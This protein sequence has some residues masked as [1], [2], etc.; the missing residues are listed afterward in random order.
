MIDRAE[1]I[2]PKRCESCG[3]ENIVTRVIYGSGIT[4]W[5]CMDCGTSESVAK[6]SNLKK[7]NNTTVNHWAQRVIKRHPFCVI[8]GSQ[9]NLEAHHII[10]VSHSRRYMYY[11]T[12]G[13]TLCHDC[14]Q[15]VHHREEKL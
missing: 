9:D 14:H 6:V 13:I 12:N 15:L 1:Y 2:I 4:R 5:V 10:P 8:C 3:S 7:R 11:D